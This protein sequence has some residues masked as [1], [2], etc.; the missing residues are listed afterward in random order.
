[1]NVYLLFVILFSMFQ[2]KDSNSSPSRDEKEDEKEEE[3][4]EC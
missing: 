2:C 4:K 3:K 1:M